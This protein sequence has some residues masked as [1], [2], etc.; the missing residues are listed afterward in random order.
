MLR[1][2]LERAH[3]QGRIVEAHGGTIG[4]A[5]SVQGAE[6]VVNGYGRS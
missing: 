2:V 6:L 5:R 1:P 3:R 4:E